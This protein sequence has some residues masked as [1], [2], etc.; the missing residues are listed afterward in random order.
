MLPAALFLLTG[1]YF[2]VE[3]QPGLE[4]GEEPALGEALGIEAG[5]GGAW[6]QT[7][8]RFFLVTRYEH[9]DI[10]HDGAGFH[11]DRSYDDISAGLRLLLPVAGPFRIY[12]DALGGSTVAH[13]ALD[14]MGLPSLDAEHFRPL[15][16]LAVGAQFRLSPNFSLGLRFQES[17]LDDSP[18]LLATAI[19]EHLDPTRT[20]LALTVGVHF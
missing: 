14:R 5:V 6:G 10:A 12:G 13:A 11:S 15:F 7:R 4:A 16:Q 19:G 3:A 17:F 20:S 2:F 18:D 9:A 1:Q 8:P